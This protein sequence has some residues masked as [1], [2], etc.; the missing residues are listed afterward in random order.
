MCSRHYGSEEMKRWIDVVSQVNTIAQMFANQ[1][2]Q[3]RSVLP[4]EK[5]HINASL[6]AWFDFKQNNGQRDR[7]TDTYHAGRTN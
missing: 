3:F 2:P 7:K 6:Y 4:H 1:V 5:H